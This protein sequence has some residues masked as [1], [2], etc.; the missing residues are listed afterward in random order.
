MIL[1]LVGIVLLVVWCAAHNEP[2][3]SDGFAH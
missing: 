3:G 2:P 1:V